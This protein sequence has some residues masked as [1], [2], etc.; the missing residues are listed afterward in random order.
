LR[1]L[2]ISDSSSDAQAYRAKRYDPMLYPNCILATNETAGQV[3]MYNEKVINSI[4]TA[5]NGG[6]T[7]SS[8]EKWGGKLPF[9]IE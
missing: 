2:T 7:V 3:L 1:G 6:R 4:Y 5:S 8:E 9:L